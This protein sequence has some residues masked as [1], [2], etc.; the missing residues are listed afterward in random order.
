MFVKL[1]VDKIK[2]HG[3]YDAYSS[4]FPPGISF[5]TIFEVCSIPEYAEQFLEGRVSLRLKEGG[6]KYHIRKS[7]ITAIPAK[8]LGEWL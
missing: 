4:W 5:K 1:D 6:V 2:S 3:R 8:P 7:D